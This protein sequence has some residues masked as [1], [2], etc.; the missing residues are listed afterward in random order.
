LSRLFRAVDKNVRA[1][2]AAVHV[3]AF[4][5]S[6]KMDFLIER[7]AAFQLKSGLHRGIPVLLNLQA[8]ALGKKVVEAARSC[9]GVNFAPSRSEERRGGSQHVRYNVH[10]P[11][12]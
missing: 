5:N 11:L 7:P 4:R 12:A 9:A 3:Q 1:G 2:G 6:F 10:R 8:V